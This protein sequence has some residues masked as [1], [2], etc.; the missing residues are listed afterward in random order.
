MKAEILGIIKIAPFLF[1]FLTFCDN[2]K[3]EVVGGGSDTET[4]LIRGQLVHYN[5]DP[6]KN[7]LVKLIPSNFDPTPILENSIPK[8]LNPSSSHFVFG[9][10][11]IRIDT[12]DSNGF[13]LFDSLN[14]G[15]SYNII[16]LDFESNKRV[17]AKFVIKFS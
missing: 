12:I 15:A 1:L 2:S 4:A 3:I 5:G 6:V 11:L 16:G 14:L 13:Y 8:L 10:N 17:F 7:G 9:K